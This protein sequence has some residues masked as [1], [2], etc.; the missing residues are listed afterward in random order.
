VLHAED[1]EIAV[2]VADGFNRHAQPFTERLVKVLETK[3]RAYFWGAQLQSMFLGTSTDGIVAGGFIET[4]FSYGYV[5]E[6]DLFFL[7]S[8]CESTLLHHVGRPVADVDTAL[9]ES[10]NE[11]IAS[12][13]S[14][15]DR[16]PDGSDWISCYYFCFAITER[17]VDGVAGKEAL[18]VFLSAELV[19]DG[20]QLN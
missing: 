20:F 12:D 8:D 7:V 16:L 4:E 15:R 17:D 5:D 18:K 10:G 19:D 13:V 2:R 3:L 6:V 9:L 11:I 14:D 1:V